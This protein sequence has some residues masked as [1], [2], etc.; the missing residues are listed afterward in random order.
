[1]RFAPSMRRLIDSAPLTCGIGRDPGCRID[2]G[3]APTMLDEHALAPGCPL[4]DSVPVI[5]VV[6]GEGADAVFDR[7]RPAA[8]SQAH[9]DVGH[10]GGR[11][12]SR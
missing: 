4:F 10:P 11:I 3:P 9:A 5:V 2:L 1:M 8:G 7:N 6:P 12:E